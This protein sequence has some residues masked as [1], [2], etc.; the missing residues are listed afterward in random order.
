M[1]S[2]FATGV[3]GSAV[4][5]A[6]AGGASGQTVDLW[7]ISYSAEKQ[8]AALDRAKA[9]FEEAHPGVTLEMTFRGVDPHKTALRIA[10][11]SDRG[12]DIYFSWAGLGLGGEFVKAGLS[13]PLDAY[14]EKYGWD[15]ELTGVALGFVDQ[16]G[17][18]KHGVPF[19]FSGEAIYY[20]K[21][22][23]EKAGLDKLPE[24]YDELV[25][26]A[27]ELK[28]AGIPAF[29]FG[30]TVNW[31]IMRLMDNII[32]AKCGAEKHD[33]LR[34][35]TLSWVEEP[36]ALASFQDMQ[37][38]AQNYILSPFMGIDATQSFNLFVADR[39]AMMLET[40]SAGLRM[41][42]A[43]KTD[44]GLF[45]FPTGTGRLYGFAEYM[46]VSTKSDNPDL[47]AEYL[48]L[49]VSQEFQQEI[50]GV[51]GSIPVNKLVV[52][53][54]NQSELDTAWQSIFG[55]YG[56]T[57]VNGDQA[58][59]LDVTTEYFRVINAVSAG[60]MTPEQA[61]IAFQTFVDNLA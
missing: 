7:S 18:G 2:R 16:F 32:E 39:A 37:M 41:V 33:A 14:Y 38:W 3:A 55:T 15:D 31:H 29:T 36:C 49:F 1:I 24:T 5:L 44:I 10:A 50:A 34:A 56:Q 21:T 13:L 42:D 54:S 4:A 61:V 40:D 22:L 47:A 20:S 19:R 46:Y 60:D 53:G 12:P 35:M 27:E 59:P 11:G 25:A 26:A 28:A 8:V 51:F 52:P 9:L 58:Y 57:F 45:A 6:M 48:D 23:F 30:G 17:E 43:N